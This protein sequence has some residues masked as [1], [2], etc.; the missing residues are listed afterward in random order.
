MG[1]DTTIRVTCEFRDWIE[2]H[3]SKGETFEDVLRRLLSEKFPELAAE[4]EVK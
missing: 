2:A 1:L 3:G 4:V